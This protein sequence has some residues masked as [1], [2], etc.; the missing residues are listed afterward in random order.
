MD[1]ELLK[2]AW[3]YGG[4]ALMGVFM[5]L[6]HKSQLASA[7][8]EREKSLS[9]FAEQLERERGA[10]AEDMKVF[11]E[12]LKAERQLCAADHERILEAIRELAIF[13]K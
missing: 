7:R 8:E 10:R 3:Q 5:F 2:V 1:A 11:R 4:F 12:E 13:R 9:A 6:L